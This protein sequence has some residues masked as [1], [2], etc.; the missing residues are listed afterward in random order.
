M[1]LFLIK[2]SYI[3]LT[4][5][6][7]VKYDITFNIVTTT[8]FTKSDEEPVTPKYEALLKIFHSYYFV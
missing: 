1:T 5:A 8:L 6:I 7:V 2:K 4:I 3:F